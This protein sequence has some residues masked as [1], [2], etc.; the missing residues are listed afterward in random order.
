MN[1]I[2]S[3]TARIVCAL[4]LSAGLF[5]VSNSAMAASC[6]ITT[7]NRYDAC[8]TGSTGATTS[9]R[10]TVIANVKA[11]DRLKDYGAAGN[12]RIYNTKSGSLLV[13]KAFTGSATLKWVSSTTGMTY[14]AVVYKDNRDGRSTN[15]KASISLQ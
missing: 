11:I 13:N 2:N 15:L 9:T 6:S 14:K 5:S 4:A 1:Q 7:S 8:D 3:K 10:K 12:G